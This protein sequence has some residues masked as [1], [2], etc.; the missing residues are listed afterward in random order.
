MVLAFA[1]LVDLKELIGTSYLWVERKLCKTSIYY[2]FS[3][4]TRCTNYQLYGYPPAL[5][6]ETIPV[7][8]VCAQDHTTRSHPCK[9]PSC[10]RGP[11][12]THPPIMCR[13]CQQSHKASDSRCPSKAI[14]ENL[15]ISRRTGNAKFEENHFAT[16]T[17][18]LSLPENVSIHARSGYTLPPPGT[19]D[20]SMEGVPPPPINT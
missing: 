15:E 18:L 5:C 20:I 17:P 4:T 14:A 1:G 3:D 12:C 2:E 7:C 10:K 16:T 6:R 8:T 9:I 13:A 19:I 11:A